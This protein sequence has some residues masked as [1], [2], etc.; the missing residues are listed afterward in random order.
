MVFKAIPG[1]FER[2]T[3]IKKITP[4]GVY[5]TGGEI[6]S[7]TGAL[8]QAIL[9]FLA[10]H[11]L[12]SGLI[13]SISVVIGQIPVTS[14]SNWTRDASIQNLPHLEKDKFILGKTKEICLDQCDENLKYLFNILKDE[15]VPF[16]ERKDLADLIL[17][18]NLNLTTES[19]RRSF[20]LCIVSV[21]IIIFTSHHSSFPIIIANLINAIREGKITKSVGRLIVR[22][23][24]REG[25]P[26]HPDLVDL[27]DS[28]A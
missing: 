6:I 9:S 12:T 27:I 14:I 7:S 3:R 19:G 15:K 1:T 21:I 25:I 2:F 17:A 10:E 28:D 11:G 24:R 5:S 13:T 18:K 26:I 8:V 23:L 4:H 20:V 16:E 22:K